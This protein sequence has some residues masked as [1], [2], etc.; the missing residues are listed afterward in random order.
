MITPD[1]PQIAREKLGL[2][3]DS[4]VFVAN[5]NSLDESLEM[6]LAIVH[7][8]REKDWKRL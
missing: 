5:Q 7:V 3:E 4:F 8:D 6:P 1:Y 2:I